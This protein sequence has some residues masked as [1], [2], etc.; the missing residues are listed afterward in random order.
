MCACCPIL[1]QLWAETDL[2]RRRSENVN[3]D[4]RIYVGYSGALKP[5]LVVLFTSSLVPPIKHAVF[6]RRTS[7]CLYHCSIGRT[8]TVRQHCR[9]QR[10]VF[11]R[12]HKPSVCC[13]TDNARLCVVSAAADGVAFL[14]QKRRLMGD[15]TSTQV[16]RDLE[17]SLRTNSIE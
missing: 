10:L 4:N 2:G 5:C 13:A 7:F 3:D 12:V 15:S 11:D 9:R 16:L 6:P 14:R 1:S 8:N 17:I